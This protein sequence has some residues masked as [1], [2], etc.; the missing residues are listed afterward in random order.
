M[1]VML[2]ILGDFAGNGATP[3][4]GRWF[5]SHTKKEYPM[6][7]RT[8]LL[9]PV[10][11]GAA[12]SLA[13]TGAGFASGLNSYLNGTYVL[14]SV[15]LTPETDQYLVA[16]DGN[17]NYSGTDINNNS[18]TIT[19]SSVTGTYS[20]AA[21]G[22]V[23]VTGTGESNS[24]ACWLSNDGNSVVCS[25][26]S[27]SQ[28]PGI[29]AGFKVGQIQSANSGS[30]VLAL[31]SLTTG[32]NNAALGDSALQSDTTG[33]Y[34]TAVG[35]LSLENNTTGSNN[36]AV[37]YGAFMTNTIGNYTTAVGYGT[38]ASNTTGTDN[39]AIGYNSLADNT[40]GSENSSFGRGTLRLNTT[41]GGLTAAGY[42]TLF[43]N[44]TGSNSTAFGYQALY[45]NTTGNS[46]IALGYQAG[47][48]VT[49]N[50][51]ID[52]GSLGSAGENGVIR[53]G[54]PSTQ[55]AAYVAGISTTQ[56]SGAPVYVTASGQLGVLA[57]SERYK[58]D[59]APIGVNSDRL[60]ALRPVSFHLKSDPAGAVQYGLI[61]EEV[62]KVYPELVIR[63]LDGK[64][65]GVRYD[66]LAP[67]LLNEVKQQKSMVRTLTEQNAEQARQLNDLQRQVG[68]LNGLKSELQ[69]VL[70]QLHASGQMLAQR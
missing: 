40:T 53:I 25:H 15:D 55:T 16:F 39:T 45:S 43:S 26:E 70:E 67:M 21:G 22:L 66:E 41:G 5:D 52:I 1:L 61:A 11:I 48:S 42:A 69:A 38:L 7:Q 18:G 63:D 65:Q 51:N 37:G 34:N 23:T 62:D 60:D 59:I 32:S 2:V 49:G 14:V 35:A 27:S 44:A 36:T 50:N 57:S 54:T 10:M 56:V 3:H 33:N 9:R 8:Q 31:A 47:F 13:G 64:V 29:L 4:G 68:E 24:T 46:N 17:G 19:S 12:L 20:V 30:G 28:N 6:T 58:T